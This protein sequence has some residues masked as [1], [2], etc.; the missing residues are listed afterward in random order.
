MTLPRHC[1]PQSI[2]ASSL[3]EFHIWPQ[4][5]LTFQKWDFYAYHRDDNFPG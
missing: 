5:H 4:I 1:Q 2:A 3:S